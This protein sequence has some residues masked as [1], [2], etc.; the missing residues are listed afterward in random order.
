[1]AEGDGVPSGW[2]EDEVEIEDIDFAEFEPFVG[3]SYIPLPPGLWA[4]KAI[5]NVKNIDN[6]C[7]RW[8]LKGTFPS[9]KKRGKG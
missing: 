5:V 1:M 7:L 3:N 8:A 4:K 2:G 6:E 9:C